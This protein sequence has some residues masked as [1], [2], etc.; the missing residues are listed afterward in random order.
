MLLFE[1]NKLFDVEDR[2]FVFSDN[3][4]AHIIYLH[5]FEVMPDPAKK[6]I[7]TRAARIFSDRSLN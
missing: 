4:K 1:D 3:L 5:D 2:T 7:A 6:Y